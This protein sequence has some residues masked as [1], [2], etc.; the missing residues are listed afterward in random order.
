MPNR[1]STTRRKAKPPREYARKKSAAEIQAK[2]AARRQARDAERREDSVES[3]DALADKRRASDSYGKVSW[4]SNAIPHV[5]VTDALTVS[6]LLRGGI[7]DKDAILQVLPGVGPF[8]WQTILRDATSSSLLARARHSIVAVRL[9]RFVFCVNCE[10]E[11]GLLPCVACAA[12]GDEPR[13]RLLDNP[14]PVPPLT[15]S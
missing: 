12:R 6:S 13:L 14:Q 15:L 3:R 7:S 9:Q 8:D 10:A 2:S 11:I 1:Q 4:E 5:R